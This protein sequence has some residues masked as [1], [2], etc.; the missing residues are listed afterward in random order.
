MWCH[1]PV[2]RSRGA[3]LATAVLVLLVAVAVSG[4]RGSCAMIAASGAPSSEGDPHSCCATGLTGATPRCCH[5]E[6]APPPTARI[7]ALVAP[8]PASWTTFTPALL[9]AAGES[10]PTA[11][12]PRPD[13][14]PPPLILRV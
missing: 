12:R 11:R 14:H 2:R 7:P 3:R 10:I 5:A 6:P 1:R 13:H 8:A 9:P 4:L